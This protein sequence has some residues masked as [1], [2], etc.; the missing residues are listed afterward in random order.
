MTNEER[1]Q[2]IC[3]LVGIANPKCQQSRLSFIVLSRSFS[4]LLE[5][6]LCARSRTRRQTILRRRKVH[7]GLK[8]THRYPHRYPHIKSG[9]RF[10][11]QYDGFN[12]RLPDISFSVAQGTGLWVGCYRSFA[13]YVR[14][15]DVIAPARISNNGARFSKCLISLA[16]AP[17]HSC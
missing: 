12:V 11:S 6:L 7:F 16:G 3:Y 5:H 15:P 17:S 10:G 4:D 9:I 13:M 8:T 1:K 2:P 14:L